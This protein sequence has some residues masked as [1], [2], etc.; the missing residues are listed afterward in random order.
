MQEHAKKDF[1][2]IIKRYLLDGVRW[3]KATDSEAVRIYDRELEDFPVT[4]D[5]YGK[6]ARVVDYSQDGMSEEDVEAMK[7][8]IVRHAYIQAENIIL[9]GRRKM[10]GR[11]QRTAEEESLEVTVKENGLLFECELVKYTDTGLYLDQAGTRAAVRDISSGMRVLNLFAYTGSFSV[12]AAAGGAESV[13]S[14]DLSNVYCAWNRRNLRNNGF[15]DERKYRTVTADARA[16]LEESVRKGDRYDL[17]IFDP[18]SFSNSH[19]ADD[20]DVK[21]DYR[22]FLFLISRLLVPGGVV[23]FSENLSGFEFSKNSLKAWWKIQE[24]TAEVRAQGFTARR[25]ALRIWVMKKTADMDERAARKR[26]MDDERLELPEENVKE[27]PETKEEQ[28]AERKAEEKRPR[29]RDERRGDRDSKPRYSDGGRNRDSRPR[30]NDRDRRDSKP[31]YSDRDSRPRY[32]D[33]DRDSERPRYNDRDS[34]PRYSDGGRDRYNDRPRYSDRD[35]NSERPRYN[36]RDSRP[37][38][39]DRDRYDERPRYSDGGR[40]RYNDRPRYSDGD[41]YSDR[42][43]YSDRDRDSRPRYSDRDRYNDRPRYSDRDR[44]SERP[45]YSD[46]DSRPRYSDGGRGRY[47]DRPRDSYRQRDSFQGRRER[48]DGDWDNDT[49]R[50]YKRE[51]ESSPKPYGYDNFMS[52][53]KRDKASTEWM[54]DTETSKGPDN[55]D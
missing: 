55:E 32:S 42:P 29:E 54:K 8:L 10:E 46:R 49:G 37:R 51:R 16:F 11:E 20:F 21:K 28:P 5:L 43:R 26:N 2:K 4:I 33:R 9:K 27:E 30:Y 7:D 14:V 3:M 38:Y 1:A 13:V 12:Y 18:P 24:V 17:V 22:Y 35:R 39:S 48:R 44:Y 15:L 41:R 36:D 25:N 50:A 23:V 6:Y 31:R 47:E 40:D 53:K 34:R 45:R 52:T 19:K